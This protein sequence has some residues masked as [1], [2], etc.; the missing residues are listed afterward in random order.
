M[1]RNLFDHMLTVIHYKHVARIFQVT[2]RAVSILIKVW[3]IIWLIIILL[4]ASLT[5]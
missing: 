5:I 1:A 2:H 3:V 4:P